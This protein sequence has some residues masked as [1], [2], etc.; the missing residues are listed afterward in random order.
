VRLARELAEI[1][2][3]KAAREKEK[4]KNRPPRCGVMVA[5]LA[6][7]TSRVGNVSSAGEPV[8]SPEDKL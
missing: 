5:S 3:E 2:E 1:R 7:P 6:S 4:D 8:F